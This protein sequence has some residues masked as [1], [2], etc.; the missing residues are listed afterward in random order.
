MNLYSWFQLIFYLVVLVA[1]AKPLGLF[2]AK[3]YQ[4]GHTFMDPVLGPVERFVYRLPGFKP[5]N[6]AFWIGESIPKPVAT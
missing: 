4:G 6:D 5:G 2:M 1:M 3:V